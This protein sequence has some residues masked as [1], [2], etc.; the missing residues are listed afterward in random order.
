MVNGWRVPRDDAS[1]LDWLIFE[2]SGVLTYRQAIQCLTPGQLRG[3]IRTGRWRAIVPGVVLAGNGH[4]T[5]Q[6]QLWTAVLV[7]SSPAA[8]SPDA[9]LAGETSAAESGVRGM[10]T[11]PIFVLVPAARHR[12]HRLGRLPLDMPRVVV[13]RTSVLPRAH[14]Q[15][16][17]PRRT[18]LPRAVVDAASWAPSDRAARTVL[19]SARQQRR[20]TPEELLAVVRHRLRI[21]R[22]ALI[23]ETITDIAGGAEALS[24][25]DLVK[26]CRR[27]GLPMPDLQERRKDA[28]G[29]TRFLDAYWRKWGLQVEV[30]GAHHMTTQHWEADMQR[31]NEV[32]IS[33]DRILRFSGYQARRKPADVADQIR[34]ALLAAGWQPGDLG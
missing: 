7:A 24:E 14:L 5:R 15:V 10:R 1:E 3:R 16:G 8:R 32:W 17:R 31:Q 21:K 27:F 4:L 29:R 18:S 6:Q 34:R 28:S 12:P 13:R 11:D 23:L 30:D 9:V 33:G 22:R 25:I 20:V 19:A 2:Q 26:L